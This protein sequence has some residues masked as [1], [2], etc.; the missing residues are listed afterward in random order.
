MLVRM[1]HDA[2]SRHKSWIMF[3]VVAFILAGLLIAIL[4]GR[5]K[6]VKRL[7]AGGGAEAGERERLISAPSQTPRET[8]A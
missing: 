4:I 7:D 1:I 5:R 2:D 3:G 8:S 6:R